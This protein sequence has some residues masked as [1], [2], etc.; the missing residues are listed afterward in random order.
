MSRRV[1]E[2][3]NCASG[4]G[5]RLCRRYKGLRICDRCWRKRESIYA[6]SLRRDKARREAQR[7]ERKKA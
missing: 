7:E 5:Y 2:L 4:C 6:I 3:A 1:A